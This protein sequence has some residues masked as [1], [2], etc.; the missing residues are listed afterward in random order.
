M[1]QIDYNVYYDPSK[2]TE[3]DLFAKIAYSLILR[4]IKYKKP[5]VCHV[6][7]KSGEGKSLSVLF[8][9]YL[10]LKMQGM[11]IKKY[12]EITN[13][14]TQMEYSTKLRQLLKDKEFKRINMLCVHEGREAMEAKEW[15][16]MF[17]RNVAHVNALC[18]AIKRM[19]IFIVSQS[20]R[21]ITKEIRYT[22]DYQIK[23][24]RRLHR[25]E[26][27]QARLLWYVLY[28]DDRDIENPKLR[29]R[30]VQGWLNLPNGRRIVHKPSFFSI[31]LV[32][33]D[34]KDMF[35]AKDREKKMEIL[36]KRLEDMEEEARK[37]NTS[38]TE[39]IDSLV[40]FYLNNENARADVIRVNKL[41][42]YKPIGS[43]GKLHD[44]KPSEIKEF[45]AK[46][47]EAL[48][49]GIAGEI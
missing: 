13:I 28:I 10:L 23:I 12:M 6:S 49:N 21:D 43:F 11:D 8:I 16:S 40:Q 14:F 39:K 27:G 37:K 35:E 36:N 18:R 44:L 24:Y 25:G 34:I 26:D 7:G 17:N 32:D 5:S 41:G 15:Q 29:K 30:K 3:I 33:G 1:L 45:E 4:R 46:F 2:E 9:M 19:A 20:I 47:N 42:N 22:L 31:P 48:E 38:Q